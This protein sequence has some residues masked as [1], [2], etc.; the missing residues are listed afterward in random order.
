MDPSLQS[1]DQINQITS[2]ALDLAIKFAPRLLVAVLIL[3]A[4]FYAGRWAGR[5]LLRALSHARL[6]PPVRALLVRI[7]EVL[8]LLVFA[9]MALQNLGVELLPLIAGL[10]IAGAGVA[11]AMQGVLG[12][13]IAGLM[14]MLSRPFNVGDYISIAGEQGVVEDITLFNTTLGHADQSKV[15][16]PNRKIVGEIL[17]NYHAIR[18]LGIE[19]GVSYK[20][21]VVAAVETIREILRANLRVLKDPDPVVGIAR[22]RDSCVVMAVAPWVQAADYGPASAEINQAILEAFRARDIVIPAPQ[23]EIR[24]MSTT[25]YLGESAKERFA[26]RDAA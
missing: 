11:L 4:G 23:R 24:V 17:H 7:T 13:G 8:V 2:T 10:G 3:V 15:V 12:N 6:E 18:Q 16:I 1:L 9:I 14:I 25:A 19:V 22:L 21:D 20:T 26:N 5:A